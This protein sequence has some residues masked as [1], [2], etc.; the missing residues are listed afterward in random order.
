VGDDQCLRIGGNV[1]G[2]IGE[3]WGRTHREGADHDL[4]RGKLEG[5]TYRK[6]GGFPKKRT[7]VTSTSFGEPD[8]PIM[9]R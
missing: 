4:Y 6:G 9:E 2:G 3:R 8:L 5:T 1:H 7:N